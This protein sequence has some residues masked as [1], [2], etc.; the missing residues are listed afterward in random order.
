M[1][2]PKAVHKISGTRKVMEYIAEKIHGD[3]LDLGAGSSKNKELYL[4]HAKTYTAFDI[5]PQP[6]IDIVGDVL[7]PDISD[8]SYDT[9]IS[10]QVIEHVRKPWVAAEQI[11]RMLR[12]G[13]TCIVTVPFMLGYHAHPHDYFRYTE[14]GLRSLF[15]D[16]GLEVE[17]CS[18]Y[19]SVWIVFW[20]MLKMRFFSPYKKHCWLVRRIRRVV[21]I[22]FCFF[23]KLSKPGIFYTSVVCIAHKPTAVQ[24]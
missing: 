10:N 8:E 15:E 18:K 16:A 12:P 24:N 14:N 17:L 2:D 13:G 4:K 5:D 22:T 11:A 23:G 1:P 19:G 7:D 6:N 21:E 9:I 3:L 20:E